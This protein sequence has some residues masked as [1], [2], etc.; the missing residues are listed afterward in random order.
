MWDGSYRMKSSSTLTINLKNVPNPVTDLT[1]FHDPTTPFESHE[2]QGLELATS[3]KFLEITPAV[4][5]SARKE[6][7]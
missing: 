2:P 6:I 3:S 5:A 7:S 1:R 4:T